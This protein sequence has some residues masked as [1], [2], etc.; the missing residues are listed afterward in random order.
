[1]RSRSSVLSHVLGSHPSIVGYKELHLNYHN[2]MSLMNMRKA[3]TSEFGSVLEGDFLLDKLLSNRNCVASKLFK[4]RTIKAIIL[5]REPE[6]TIKSIMNMGS[7]TN[8]QWYKDPVKAT[9]YYCARLSY[10]EQYSKQIAGHYFFVQSSDLVKNTEN[11]LNALTKWLDLDEPLDKHYSIFQDTGKPGY[12]DPSDC[13][14]TGILKTTNGYPDI[15]IPLEVLQR[16][17]DCYAKCRQS[18]L[19]NVG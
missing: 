14:K 12:G 4:K 2:A 8:V 7:I 1:M 9:D 5:L 13:I 17:E 19:E 3:I 6:A 11:T 10:I 16:A 18:L 15:E